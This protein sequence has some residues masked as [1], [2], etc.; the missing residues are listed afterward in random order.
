MNYCRCPAITK[1]I[2][3]LY[4]PTQSNNF[5]VYS[6]IRFSSSSSGVKPSLSAYKFKNIHTITELRENIVNQFNLFLKQRKESNLPI[7]YTEQPVRM[8]DSFLEAFLAFDGAHH[9]KYLSLYNTVR[10]GKLFEDLDTFAVAVAARHCT[11]HLS[12]PNNI[13]FACVKDFF[14]NC[15]IIVMMIH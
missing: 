3:Y 4:V 13:H 12:R 2:S 15:I 8:R 14:N 7:D 11:A 1:A 6:F 9:L 10:I 5:F